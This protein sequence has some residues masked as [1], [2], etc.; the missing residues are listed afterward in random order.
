MNEFSSYTARNKY[1]E[2]SARLNKSRGSRVLVPMLRLRSQR[3]CAKPSERSCMATSATW[4][5]SM[6]CKLRAEGLHSK[7]AS[8]TRSFIACKTGQEMLGTEQAQGEA[9]DYVQVTTARSRSDMTQVVQFLA[10]I[11]RSLTSR[12]FFRRMAWSRRASNIL[13]PVTSF[14]D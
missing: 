3:K 6:A 10:T 11:Q 14:P 2:N 7:F 5:V 12:S 1:Q 13:N 8:F 4:D 9:L